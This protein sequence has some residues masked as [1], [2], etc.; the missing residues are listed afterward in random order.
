VLLAAQG[1]TTTLRFLRWRFWQMFGTISYGLY[2]IHQPV[3]GIM[4]GL[5]LDARP[6]IPTSPQILVTFAALFVAIGL[7][8]AS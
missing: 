2:L 4:H 3:A 8:W 5:I 1:C 7:A 6:D